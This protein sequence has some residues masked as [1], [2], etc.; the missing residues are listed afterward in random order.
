M[1]GSPRSFGDS[2]QDARR[3]AARR[4]P[5]ITIPEGVNVVYPLQFYKYFSTAP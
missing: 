1:I 4:L 3:G 5:Q 2:D